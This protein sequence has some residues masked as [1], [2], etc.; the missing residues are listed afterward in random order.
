MIDITIWRFRNLLVFLLGFQM[1]CAQEF[2]ILPTRCA[3]PVDCVETYCEVAFQHWNTGDFVAMKSCLDTALEVATTHHLDTLSDAYAMLWNYYGVYYQN[4]SNNAL[5]IDAYQRVLEIDV[6]LSKYDTNFDRTYLASDYQN[7]AS[8]LSENG[9][10]T[11]ALASYQKALQYAPAHHVETA[12]ILNNMALDFQKNKQLDS[13]LQ[14]YQ[15]T[16]L[17]LNRL[18]NDA[19]TKDVWLSYYFNIATYWNA[20][21]DYRKSSAVLKTARKLIRSQDVNNLSYYHNALGGAELFNGNYASAKTHLFQ[22]LDL[23]IQQWGDK[24]L[25]VANAYRSIGEQLYERQGSPAMALLY[26][27]KA[28]AA[29]VLDFG[30]ATDYECNPN[31]GQAILDRYT[32]LQLLELKAGALVKLDHLDLGQQTYQLAIALLDDLRFNYLAEGSKFR[33]MERAIP[34]YERA[35]ALALRFG[36]SEAAFQLA[37]RGKAT[38]LLENLNQVQ[39]KAFAGVSKVWLQRERDFKTKISVTERAL[40]EAVRAGNTPFEQP[41]RDT[42]F[43]LRQDFQVFQA[44]LENNYPTYFQ[45][46]YQVKYPT[47]SDIQQ[48]LLDEQTALLEFFSGDSTIFLFSITSKQVAIH[49]FPADSLQKQQLQTL[50]NTLTTPTANRTTFLAFSMAAFS[51]F[52][53]YFQPAIAAWETKIQRLLIVPDGDFA[54]IPFQTLLKHPINSTQYKET[55]FDTLSF[56]VQDYAMVYAYSATLALTTQ[57]QHDVI[58]SPSWVA[59]APVFTGDHQLR[60]SQDEVERI[61]KEAKGKIFLQ[62]QATQANFREM[63]GQYKILHL[64]THAIADRENPLLSKIYFHDQHLTIAEIYNLQITAH[65]VVLSACETGI[66]EMKR[67]EGLF[68]LARAFLYAGC[69]SLVASLWKVEEHKS[70]EVMQYFY[71]HLLRGESTAKALQLAQCQYLSQVSAKQAAHPFYW[72]AFTV[73]GDDRQFSVPF[74]KKWAKILSFLGVA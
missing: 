18:P 67:G 22:A 20:K 5:A 19:T 25:T 37:E 15:Q 70:S 7:I 50:R 68:S 48:Q 72:S 32:L 42:L 21:R 55:R 65:L 69:P 38:L 39:A 27:Q 66:G 57:A 64:S 45:L 53:T 31:L 26:Y 49:T 71:H 3:I 43:Q 2:S 16:F 14:Y 9:D 35:I 10:Y 60:Y 34:I 59:F 11:T 33:L 61:Q 40:Y 29:L 52:Q 74:Y 17:L 41:L 1:L 13:A 12:I 23:R 56:L 62:E 51:I 4:T 47:L 58:S 28:I 6:M 30:E 44:A 73:I 46:K 8:L 54:A 24:H 63:A 36:D